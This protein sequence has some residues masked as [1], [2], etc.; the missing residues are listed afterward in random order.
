MSSMILILIGS[1]RMEVMEAIRARRSIRKYKP[2]PVDDRTLE[3][4][5]EAASLAP[6]WANVQPWRFIVVRDS[7]LKAQLAEALLYDNPATKAIA[8]APIVIVA[9]AELGVSGYEP[10]KPATEEEPSPEK[11]LATDGH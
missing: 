8:G 2:D 1:V 3:S 7:N 9:C 11:E 6:S 4:V 10:E 5:L